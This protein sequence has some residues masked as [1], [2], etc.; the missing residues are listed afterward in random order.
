M[1]TLNQDDEKEHLPSQSNAQLKVEIPVPALIGVDD[2]IDYATEPIKAI[3]FIYYLLYFIS[4]N[5]SYSAIL[6]LSEFINDTLDVFSLG[7]KEFL[8]RYSEWSNKTYPVVKNIRP[9]QILSVHYGSPISFDLLGI[10]SILEFIRDIGKDA[11]WRANHEKLLAKSEREL[12]T[13]E[14]EKAKLEIANQKMALEKMALELALQKVE[15]IE[16]LYN[17]PL[18]SK[19][20][21]AIA[22]VLGPKII[23]IVD[24]KASLSLVNETTK[25][26]G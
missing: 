1:N 11:L 24:K 13:T 22:S 6:D 15:L 2:F 20:Q 4:A 26:V 9:L 14:V 25:K 23:A 16:R 8:Y 17:L 10:G 19:E 21:T 12:K 7:R 18:G 5:S 3:D